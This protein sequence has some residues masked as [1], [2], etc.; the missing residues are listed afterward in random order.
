MKTYDTG[1]DELTLN[2][3]VDGQLDPEMERMVVTAMQNHPDVR[4]L[5][6]T[7]DAADELRSV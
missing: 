6:Y 5:L 2:A 3:F 7:S 1:L 4:C